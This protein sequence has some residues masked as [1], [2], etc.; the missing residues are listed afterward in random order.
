MLPRPASSGPIGLSLLLALLLAGGLPP[1]ASAQAPDE[2]APAAV[3]VIGTVHLDNPGR[4]V[5]NPEVPD[6]LS[7]EKQRELQ[8]L[9]DSLARFRP[10]KMAVEI[11]RR[12][13][14]RIDSLYRAF[15]AGRLDTSFAVGDFTSVRS[16]QYQLGFRLADRLDHQRVW[17]VD[18]MI[19][20]E[21]G[22]VSS[23]AEAHDPALLRYLKGFS[24]GPLTTTIDSLLQHETL[25]ALYRFLN[26]PSTVEQFRAP[27]V[28]M[29]AAVTDS[30][31]VG[32]DVITDYHRRN[33]RIFANV[34][35]VA[36]PGD[37]IILIFGAGHSPYLRPLIQA[38]PQMQFV[39]PLDYL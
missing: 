18:H 36:D 23:F 4:D 39:D 5:N 32:A 1:A 2:E 31:F 30:T 11:R 34:A 7:P 29:A 27:N 15:Q 38:S 17:A 20:M 3:M 8:R 9:R 12:H 28:R 16:E 21:I 37:R 22:R 19:P 6:V 35:R 10:T 26:R 13:Q 14:P 33:L 24:E 25:G